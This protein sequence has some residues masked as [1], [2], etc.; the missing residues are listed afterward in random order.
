MVGIIKCSFICYDLTPKLFH[1]FAFLIGI[2]QIFVTTL[3]GK[4]ITLK[5]KPS[6]T[7]ESVKSRIKYEEGIL[8]YEQHLLFNGK[9]LAD[10]CTLADY[11]VLEKSTLYLV[12]NVNFGESK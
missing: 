5:V 11:G 2:F 7:V 4:R 1:N 10:E 12:L 3:T 6:D 8:R 9:P